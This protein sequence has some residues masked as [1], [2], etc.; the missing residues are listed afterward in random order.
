[1]NRKGRQAVW[2]V[3]VI[4]LTAVVS[5]FFTVP[6]KVGA[7]G[8]TIDDSPPSSFPSD[9][10]ADWKAQD[11][12]NYDQLI[13]SI[14][15]S[16]KDQALASKVTGSG[17]QGYLNA[18]HWRRVD[19]L[20]PYKEWIKKMVCAR[21]HDIGTFI[22][23][24]T[25]DLNG[26]GRGFG[27]WGMSSGMSSDYR[28]GNSG[29][30][31]IHLLDFA[32]Y[33]PAKS[34][35]IADSK[36]CVRDPCP[37]YD[38]NK[39]VFA[40]SKDNNGYH[41]YDI[42][43]ATKTTRQLTNDLEGVQISD[44]EPCVTP[45]GDIIF[46]SSRCFQHVDCNI[47]LVSN[48]FICNKDGKYLRRISY[49]QVNI[50][51]PTMME[52]GSVMYNRWE[53]NDKNVA[54]VMG[55]FTMNPDGTR[56]N[57]FYGNQTSNPATFQMA[58]SVPGNPMLAVST[59]G[60][61]MGPHAGDI[62]LVDASRVRNGTS[63]VT[64]ICP[65]GRSLQSSGMDGVPDANK[66]FQNP[67]PLDE[68]C[69]LV[70]Y[71]TTRSGSFSVYWMDF[72]GKRELLASGGNQSVSQ[73]VSLMKRPIPIIPKSMVDYSK[74]TAAVS[75]VNVYYSGGAVNAMSGVSKGTVKKIR[76][77]AMEYRTYPAHGNTGTSAYQM[78]PVGRYGCSWEAK[79]ICGEADVEDDGSAAFEVPPRTPIFLQLIDANG[80]CVQTMRSWMT[81]QPGERFDC[82]GCHEDKNA[83]PLT[84][85]PKAVTPVPLKPFYDLPQQPGS[86]YFLT[87]I[88][89]VLDANCV[90]SG[91]HD[92]NHS[93]LKLNENI[94]D[95]SS[96]GGEE[97]DA[98]RKWSTSYYNL[99][100]RSYA[101]YNC[102][103]GG[104]E[105]IRPKSL[106]SPV[107]GV[108]KKLLGGHNNAP[109]EAIEKIAAWIDLGVPHSGTY[110]D[111]MPEDVLASYQKCMQRRE[112]Q[113]A[114]EAKN[115][116]EMIGTAASP[117]NRTV[118]KAT[119]TLDAFKAHFLPTECMLSLDL[120]SEGNIKLLDLMGRQVVSRKISRDAF[121]ESAQQ[122]IKLNIPSGTYIVKFDGVKVTG[123]EV[124]S[125]L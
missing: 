78:G 123:E 79:W 26:D 51:N 3:Q 68:T 69:M 117:D 57:E 118:R 121:L 82:M 31:A 8:V 7:A 76:V 106:G 70:S 86:F 12:T 88:Q 45:S 74:K 87:V 48:L 80:V 91:C 97:R 24:G 27:P 6:A 75:V 108:I 38:G 41:L 42:D 65:K 14:K 112:K 99:S 21:H 61:H 18:C 4:F 43:L 19:R 102:I 55:I 122:N 32:N 95:A 56:Q 119:A 33:Y 5:L 72:D 116:A 44:M 40:W 83:A 47:N 124:I 84:A 92:A 1:M 107:S 36:G 93:K 53:Y 60:G 28:S 113:E 13:S 54:N 17:E 89:P 59:L 34:D 49:D 110:T 11:G 29:G 120:P 101:S 105:G 111:D 25:E 104:A 63:G 94:V 62:C 46:C 90:K 58:R 64:M 16:I 67:Y 81:L 20:R 114:F 22:I 85:T 103:F 71:R 100:G 115:I 15:S 35:I 66:L 98:Y 39:I 30:T 23:G 50:F 37:T 2:A 10:V 77:V 96:L 9:I 125:I 52:D 109:K 73:P